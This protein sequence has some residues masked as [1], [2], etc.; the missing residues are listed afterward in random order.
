MK[1]TKTLFGI[2][3]IT[4]AF[5]M[6][7]SSQIQIYQFSESITGSL[8]MSVQDV[9]S[10]A[11][12]GSAGS[13]LLN[14]NTLSETIYLDPEG[15]TL[16]QVG[17]ISVTP[18]APNIQFE[19]TQTISGPPPVFPNP[20]PPPTNVLGSVT[21]NLALSGGNLL[22]FDT[23]IQPITW[24]GS[25]YTVES[26]LTSAAFPVSGSYS[27]VTGGQTYTGEFSYTLSYC[28]NAASTFSTIS[29]SGYP[30]ANPVSAP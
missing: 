1:T 29:I 8:T 16:R 11:P 25:A 27:L 7:G 24:N 19:E 30:G 10:N 21:V 18:S 2:L 5:A 23:G 9:D 26:G 14:F 28:Y 4:M 20:P 13:F 3:G 17:T 22:S 12:S 15:E 6:T